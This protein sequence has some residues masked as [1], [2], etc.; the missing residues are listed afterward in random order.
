MVQRVVELEKRM[1]VAVEPSPEVELRGDVDQ[2]EQLLINVVRNAVDASLETGG[3][4]RVAWRPNADWIEIEIDDE[5]KGLPDKSNLFVPFFTTKP[6]GSGIGL[7][8]SRQIA[9]AHGGTIA[10]DNRAD[11]AGCRAMLRLPLRP[12]AA[13]DREGG[14]RG[15]DQPAAT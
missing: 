4:V 12:R 6:S 7:A 13:T 5:G 9:E 15:R 8:L 11:G 1:P 3:A 14:G 2:I 10:L